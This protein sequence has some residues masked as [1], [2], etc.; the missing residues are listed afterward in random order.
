MIRIHVGLDEV[1][2]RISVREALYAMILISK[3]TIEI[4]G[5]NTGD[6]PGIATVSLCNA[7][8]KHLGFPAELLKYS[9]SVEEPR[10]TF[11]MGSAI[12][13]QQSIPLIPN[14]IYIWSTLK[15]DMV[16]AKKKQPAGFSI[17]QLGG[18]DFFLAK[19]DPSA[20][21]TGINYF[22]LFTAELDKA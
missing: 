3:E 20:A 11:M 13:V 17:P 18:S 12:R 6:E 7:M 14:V 15:Y 4:V 22:E 5:P 2:D 1:T 16:K 21:W 19:T 10:K 8:A 9:A